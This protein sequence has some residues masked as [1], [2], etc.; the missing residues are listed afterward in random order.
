MS[1]PTI[2]L[3]SP[4]AVEMAGRIIKCEE[5]HREKAKVRQNDGCVCD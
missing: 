1:G 3:L 2:S 4:K 5:E